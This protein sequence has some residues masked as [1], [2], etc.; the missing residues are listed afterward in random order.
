MKSKIIIALAL[1]ATLF[2]CLFAFV[3]CKTPASISLTGDNAVV[4]VE[5]K[6]T[7]A[8]PYTLNG[9]L[10]GNQSIECTVELGKKIVEI[11]QDKKSVKGL[12]AG[13]ALVKIKLIKDGVVDVEL[14]VEIEVKNTVALTAA[15][16]EIND[17]TISESLKDNED[18][19]KL[20]NEQKA[21]WVSLIDNCKTEEQIKICVMQ[22]LKALEELN[23]TLLKKAEI[24][25]TIDAIVLNKEAVQKVY[26][27]LDEAQLII[28]V[29]KKMPEFN[30]IKTGWLETVMTAQ[31]VA[32]IGLL[33]EAVN[34]QYTNMINSVAVNVM[35]AKLGTDLDDTK[36]TLEQLQNALQA[37]DIELKKQIEEAIESIRLINL[38]ATVNL[39]GKTI[40]YDGLY[41]IIKVDGCEVEY[42]T[43]NG[44]T[45]NVMGNGL[46]NAGN[47]DLR[48]IVESVINEKTIKSCAYASMTIL[49][50][51]LP[52]PIWPHAENA[53]YVVYT[54]LKDIKLVGGVAGEGSPNDPENLW[55]SRD[56][57]WFRW[58]LEERELDPMNFGGYSV[59]LVPYLYDDNGNKVI[60][61]GKYVIDENF[62]ILRQTIKVGIKKAYVEI[63]PLQ[64]QW[65]NYDGKTATGI[66]YGIR[67]FEDKAMTNEINLSTKLEEYIRLNIE[68]EFAI[69]DGLVAAVNVGDWVITQGTK[70]AKDGALFDLSFNN[71]NDNKEEIKYQ[72][73]P[74]TLSAVNNLTVEKIYDGTK[75]APDTNYKFTDY[76]LTGLDENKNIITIDM[77]IAEDELSALVEN[78]TFYDKKAGK[79]KVVSYNYANITFK[80]NGNDLKNYVLQKDADGNV[81]VAITIT[82]TI[83]E[84]PITR[85]T[86]RI[87]SR[88]YN[89]TDIADFTKEI[90]NSQQINVQDVGADGKLID[91]EQLIENV[92]DILNDDISILLLSDGKFIGAN[93][94]GKNVG[95]NKNVLFNNGVQEDG[96]VIASW[97]LSG[98]DKDNYV[99]VG[100]LTDADPNKAEKIAY[101]GD[102]TKLMANGNVSITG[103]EA[104]KEYNG[105]AIV[106][107]SEIKKNDDG[108]FYAVI[109]FD[110]TTS[111]ICQD[112]IIIDAVIDGGKYWDKVNEQSSVGIHEIAFDDVVKFMTLSGDADNY[113]WTGAIATGTGTITKKT[114]KF[115]LDLLARMNSRPYDATKI[116]YAESEGTYGGLLNFVDGIVSD[117]HFMDLVGNDQF[118]VRIMKDENGNYFNGM[119]ENK[120]VL[121]DENGKAKE[122]IAKW[123]AGTWELSEI[124]GNS[125][126]IENYSFEAVEFPATGAITKVNITT[127]KFALVSRIYDGTN[128]ANMDLIPGYVDGNTNVVVDSTKVIIEGMI[129]GDVLTVTI[130][131]NGKYNDKNAAPEKEAL[132]TKWNI[133]GSKLLGANNDS[134]NYTFGAE[135]PAGES[136]PLTTVKGV[137]EIAQKKITAITVSNVKIEKNWNGNST[138]DFLALNKN[139]ADGTATVTFEGI[140]TGDDLSIKITADGQYGRF[141]EGVWTTAK[142]K[143]EA[144]DADYDVRYTQKNSEGADRNNYFIDATPVMAKGRIN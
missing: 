143:L 23:V 133:T 100:A 94:T 141:I 17:Y 16:K 88:V 99:Y 130:N 73:I 127:V 49:K 51:T 115:D 116:A 106:L 34:T 98:E 120:N 76:V 9:E 30:A 36:D 137:G 114:I 21:Y 35:L 128:N 75:S 47:Y 80:E 118:N 78:A 7:Q 44:T 126:I 68:G 90:K 107:T 37:A 95:V 74:L 60:E 117:I 4:E 65:K 46:K 27:N 108:T 54:K 86:G 22:S 48:V 111:A 33:M 61:D 144:T 124:I 15:K 112:K 56:L 25:N 32:D 50:G 5:V 71:L 57:G 119:F 89:G 102:I 72:I 84:R 24:K 38:I 91:A 123:A 40:T 62:N 139:I 136:L 28:E 63:A 67:V 132:F 55:G 93:N 87:E 8:L 39:N 96:T 69:Y 82:G 101:L 3:G 53:E 45:W 58:L 6:S 121:S 2:V 81:N 29:D 10:L 138:A 129:A 41:H 105:N 83:H 70:A 1:V 26:E 18:M 11:S 43:D 110:D 122:K 131:D 13:Y 19:K 42:S 97:E 20:F 77:H 104:T 125:G 12:V 52:T 142:E 66:K 134:Q 64:G 109:V 140:I 31:N 92:K 113:D 103:M 59:E 135:I 79:N 85:L 14:P